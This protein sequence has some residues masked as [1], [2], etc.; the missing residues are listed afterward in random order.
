MLNCII[1]FRKLQREEA[2]GMRDTSSLSFRKK[3]AR[4]IIPFMMLPG[5]YVVFSFRDSEIPR[6]DC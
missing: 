4:A 5:R 2:M 1:T 6:N 3:L